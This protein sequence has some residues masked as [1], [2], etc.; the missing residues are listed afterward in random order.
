MAVI[1]ASELAKRA[2]TRPAP[3]PVASPAPAIDAQAIANAIASALKGVQITAPAVDVSVQPAEVTVQN[4]TPP[5]SWR[6][7]VKRDKDGLIS[8]IVATAG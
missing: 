3:A 4:A 7:A 6:F 1:P 5:K 2:A 8:E